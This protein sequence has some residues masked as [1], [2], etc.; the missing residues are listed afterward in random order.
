MLINIDLSMIRNWLK[1]A[2]KQEFRETCQEK[3][4]KRETMKSAI[5]RIDLTLKFM[6]KYIHC[7]CFYRSGFEELLPFQAKLA[8]FL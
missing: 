4:S 6:A 7:N 8:T 1:V 3:V 5:A 2:I